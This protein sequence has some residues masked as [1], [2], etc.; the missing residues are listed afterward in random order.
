MY[1]QSAVFGFEPLILFS[2]DL[3]LSYARRIGQLATVY[4]SLTT[5][6]VLSSIE[7]SSQQAPIQYL[8]GQL[9][10]KKHSKN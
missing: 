1:R 2:K 7:D 4:Y 6:Y 8:F 9:I 5:G 10:N 3:V